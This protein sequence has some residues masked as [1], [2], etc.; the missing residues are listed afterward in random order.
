MT[1]AQPR[2]TIA[3]AGKASEMTIALSVI[4]FIVGTTFAANMLGSLT[5]RYGP[6][7]KWKNTLLAGSIAA[8]AFAGGYILIA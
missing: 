6:V 7:R 8:A 5:G 3:A 2:R 4:L 1:A